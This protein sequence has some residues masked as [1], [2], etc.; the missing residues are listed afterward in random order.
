MPLG[1]SLSLLVLIVGAPRLVAAQWSATLGLSAA[2]LRQD[3]AL[4]ASAVNF[5]SS[6]SAVGSRHT[7]AVVG[8]GSVGASDARSAQ[9]LVSASW[10][11][12]AANR[13]RWSLGATGSLF[14]EWRA[15]PSV[16]AHAVA[17]EQLRVGRGGVWSGLSLGVVREAQRNFGVRGADVG[18]WH[19]S[20]T[21]E[22][23]LHA[24]VVDTKSSY[25]VPTSQQQ[26]VRIT[27]PAT[28]GDGR[29][30]LRWR[31]AVDDAH[32]LR[33]ALHGGA[34]YIARGHGDGPRVKPFGGFDLEL[35]VGARTSLTV[36][37]GRALSDLARGTPAS[38]HLSAGL[39][40]RVR[41][42]AP[43]AAVMRISPAAPAVS[44]EV[45]GEGTTLVVR[46]AGN[47]VEVAGTF[48]EWAPMPLERRGDRWMFAS[49]L[50]SGT[51][52]LL[53]RI[54]GGAWQVPTNLASIDDGDG[55]RVALIVVP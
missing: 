42:G 5:I 34:R 17:R 32:A 33:I 53:V 11:A 48:T 22:T 26:F 41:D 9:G 47:R 39:Q 44:L 15:A 1:R 43:R 52:R 25:A 10:S 37:G 49:V 38:R 40:F 21:L 36:S 23:A 19:A 6:L 46:A 28:Y 3:D 24:T 29:G 50:P 16:S 20:R 27:E 54:D 45:G 8:I 4:P 14:S 12:P 2:R 18:A 13:A 51:H 7:A 35:D 31:A 30:S 55:G